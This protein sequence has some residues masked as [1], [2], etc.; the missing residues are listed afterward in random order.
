[1]NVSLILPSTS[2]A[3]SSDHRK[4]GWGIWCLIA[5][6]AG[7]IG[8]GM[9]WVLQRWGTSELLTQAR[10]LAMTDVK[11]SQ[12]AYRRYL[13]RNP[14]DSSINLE[15]ADLLKHREPDAAFH[16]LRTIRPDDQHFA[17]A[18]R[19]TAAL[20]L[21]LGRDYDAVGPLLFLEQTFSQDASI[22]LALAELRFRERDFESAL[23]HARG[24]RVLNPQQTGAWLVEAESLDELKRPSEMVQPL[25]AALRLDSDL[26]QVHLNL[27]YVYPLVA[28][29]DEAL[30]HVQWFLER[31]PQSAA[32]YRTLAMVQRARGN[33]NEALLA[34]QMSLKLK[35]NQ[36][37]ATLLEAELLLFLRRPDEAYQVLERMS[38]MHGPE[39]RLLTLLQRAAQ[40]SG[41]KAESDNWRQRLSR[42]SPN[43]RTP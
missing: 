37:E 29:E 38:E 6:F 31:F 2:T 11:Q 15:L 42:L 13:Q 36:L 27:A 22:Q 40:L 28:R 34:V 1:M 17:D 20:A 19:R 7:V 39:F 26:P 9:G 18:A 32:G 23:K 43:G 30:E 12:L 16:V 24:S 5:L 14:R 8:W 25:E 10:S 41:R 3:A 21:E 35:P 4:R 33:H